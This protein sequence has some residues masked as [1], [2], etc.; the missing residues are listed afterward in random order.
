MGNKRESYGVER[1]CLRTTRASLAGT[2]LVRHM[3]AGEDDGRF[4]AQR[5]AADAAV[6]EESLDG[7]FHARAL[8]LLRPREVS[9]EDA[10]ERR[11]FFL[12]ATQGSE[13]ALD[14]AADVAHGGGG[15]SVEDGL[16]EGREGHGALEDLD[17]SLER[18]AL[19]L[20][21][22]LEG[23][24]D[25]ATAA[26]LGLERD[27]LAQR[28]DDAHALAQLRAPGGVDGV[29]GGGG[30][31][32]GDIVGV[33]VGGDIVGDIVGGDIV[34]VIVGDIVIGDIS[35]I[36]VLIV[37]M[38][39][40]V[41]VIAMIDVTAIDRMTIVIDSIAHIIDMITIIITL[42]LTHITH[43]NPVHSPTPLPRRHLRERH[44]KHALKLLQHPQLHKHPL[45]H[46]SPSISHL[47]LPKPKRRPRRRR[48]ARR[49]SRECFLQPPQRRL[50]VAT[51]RLQ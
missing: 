46:T 44:A 22:E 15:V 37:H 34:I 49:H 17:E 32:A 2:P 39:V 5:A 36:V 35:V 6:G 7:L 11:Q 1:V 27:G 16:E 29:S 42:L 12:V 43:T 21:G 25:L 8:L 31:V 20:F 23:C 41:H 14:D 45:F 47:T 30:G 4:V 24:E 50:P 19:A 33:I 13:D 3:S 10:R 18:G 38:I 9:P 48:H 28:G 26:D 51:F 40:I